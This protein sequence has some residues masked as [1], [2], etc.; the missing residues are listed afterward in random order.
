MAN[1]FG[2]TIQI[3]K[4]KKEAL[5]YYL[6]SGGST[7]QSEVEKYLLALYDEKVP[8]DVRDFIESK[9]KPQR[10]SDKPNQNAKKEG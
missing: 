6:L 5:E 3:G 8:K 1:M 4:D 2:I 7:L 10:G 9:N